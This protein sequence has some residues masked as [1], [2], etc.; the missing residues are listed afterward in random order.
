MVNG[1]IHVWCNAGVGRTEIAT[2][3]QY[4][5]GKRHGVSL[6]KINRRYLEVLSRRYIILLER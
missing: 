2:S 1:V 5:D 3:K 6:V 4:N